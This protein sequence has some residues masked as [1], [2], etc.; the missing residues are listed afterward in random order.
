[1]TGNEAVHKIID[2]VKK[3]IKDNK[4]EN[5]RAKSN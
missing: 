5:N 4:T 1:M 3:V 2:E